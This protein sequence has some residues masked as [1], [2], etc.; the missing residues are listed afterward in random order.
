MIYNGSENLEKQLEPNPN[1]TSTHLLRRKLIFVLVQLLLSVKYDALSLI[2]NIHTL[3]TFLVFFSKFL[4]ITY[5]I[6][7]IILAK[8]TRRLDFNCKEKIFSALRFII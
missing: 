5:H 1:R 8:T 2:Y 6:L 3:F 4:S 7:N